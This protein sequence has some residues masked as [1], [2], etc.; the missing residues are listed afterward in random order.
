MGGFGETPV[1]IL[2]V[3][4]RVCR[5]GEVENVVTWLGPFAILAGA[6]NN[7]H[8]HSILSSQLLTI[9][10]QAC[11]RYSELQFLNPPYRVSQK[12]RSLVFKGL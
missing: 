8:S 12:K 6:H 1:I 7:R 5:E 9:S 10:N 4:V 3:P 2:R 11:K